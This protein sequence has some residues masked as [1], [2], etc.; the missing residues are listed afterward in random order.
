M[1][2]VLSLAFVLSMLIFISCN[3]VSNNQNPSSEQQNQ[4]VSVP[5]PEAII[6]K[7]TA[8]F[9]N[10]VPIIMNAEKTE[11]VSF[12]AP[13]DLKYKGEIALPTV[14]ES[15]FLLDNRGINENAVFLNI[16]YEEYMTLDKAPSK[17]ELYN[18]I[19]DRDPFI[20]MY[21]CGKRQQFNNEIK[22]L[23]AA[24]MENNFNG[25]KQLK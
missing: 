8:N 5:G 21:S 18:L 11:I 19:I 7:T 16:T 23:N 10:M 24:I 25:F 15:G 12:P 20:I 2:K 22:E 14:L 1:K 17:D 9:N 4:V 13:G 3:Q 6:Y